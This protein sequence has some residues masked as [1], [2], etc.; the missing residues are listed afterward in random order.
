MPSQYYLQYAQDL[1]LNE[2]LFKGKQN[3]FFLDIG[4]HDGITLSNS[5]FFEK[6]MGWTAFV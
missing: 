4:A 6:E 1:L 3:G 2:V 5:C